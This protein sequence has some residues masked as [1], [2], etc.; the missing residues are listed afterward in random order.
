MTKTFITVS[1]PWW[2]LFYIVCITLKEHF[3]YDWRHQV[4]TSPQNI[5]VTLPL[6]LREKQTNI[7]RTFRDLPAQFGPGVPVLKGKNEKNC[8]TP[9]EQKYR[10][11]GLDSKLVPVR[12][13]TA[14]GVSSCFVAHTRAPLRGGVKEVHCFS[15]KARG[16]TELVSLWF[17]KI[18]WILGRYTNNWI[19]KLMTWSLILK[20]LTWLLPFFIKKIVENCFQILWKWWGLK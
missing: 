5:F 15:V 19:I 20:Q 10:N 9:L 3:V 8:H 11:G 13:M 16:K 18:K 2:N 6:Y 12:H 14:Q 4:I 7:L 1:A 17:A